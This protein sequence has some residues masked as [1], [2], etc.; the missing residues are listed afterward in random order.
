MAVLNRF[1]AA[2]DGTRSAASVLEVRRW[3]KSLGLESWGMAAWAG[4]S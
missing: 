2:F 1:I 4:L 3:A